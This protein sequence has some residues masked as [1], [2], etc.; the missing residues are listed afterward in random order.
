MYVRLL[1]SASVFCE[2]PRLARIAL[3]TA[4]KAVLSDIKNIPTALF[5]ASLRIQPVSVSSAKGE[6][7]A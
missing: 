5:L 6:A 3:S 4:A 1:T 7:S 2:T